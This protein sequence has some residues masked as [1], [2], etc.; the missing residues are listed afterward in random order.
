[1][2]MIIVHVIAITAVIAGVALGNAR[3]ES[4]PSDRIDHFEI[5]ALRLTRHL[6]GERILYADGDELTIRE[7]RFIERSGG[8]RWDTGRHREEGG[9]DCRLIQDTLHDCT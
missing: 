4:R 6:P 5:R 3:R 8:E 7:S 1:M 9:D 2:I